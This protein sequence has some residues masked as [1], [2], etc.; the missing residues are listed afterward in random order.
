MVAIINTEEDLVML[1]TV[2][3]RKNNILSLPA[4]KGGQFP[5]NREIVDL[6]PQSYNF[7]DNSNSKIAALLTFIVKSPHMSR[8]C[9]FCPNYLRQSIISASRWIWMSWI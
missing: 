9:A 2:V 7:L 1:T 3:A 8:L 4:E 5:S 6:F